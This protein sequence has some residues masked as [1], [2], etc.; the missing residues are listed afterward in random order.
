MDNFI[1]MTQNPAENA[2]QN[3][4]NDV[5]GQSSTMAASLIQHIY[6]NAATTMSH[7]NM[8]E[9]PST[10]GAPYVQGGYTSLLLGVDQAATL[11]QPPIR[12]LYFDGVQN[13]ED[14]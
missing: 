10:M 2:M 13:Q 5:Y 3:F 14:I 8:Y 6:V 12:K 11:Q 1:F 7:F 9:K 4:Q